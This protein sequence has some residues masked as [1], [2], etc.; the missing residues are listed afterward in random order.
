MLQEIS[1]Y[2]NEITAEGAQLIAQMLVGKSHLRTLGLS[3]NIIGQCGARELASLCIADLTSLTRLA[4]ESNLI[5]NLGLE[6]ISRKLVDNTSL[7]EIF[8]YNN[9]LDDDPMREFSA[10][11]GNKAHL[12]TLGLEYNRVRSR[13][14]NKV[15]EALNALP[16]FERLF[17]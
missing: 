11:L 5:G 8:L 2:S 9:D 17:F 3:N 6:A 10:M 13:G 14:A 7:K 16:S 4:L 15:F 1:L 12:Q